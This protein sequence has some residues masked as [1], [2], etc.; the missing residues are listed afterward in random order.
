MAKRT[1]AKKQGQEF[2]EK[3]LR[4]DIM[5]EGRAIGLPSGTVKP[6]AATVAEKVAGWVAGRA[7]VTEDDLTRV[8]A[9]EL[10]K[11]NR[12]LAYVYKNRD[13]II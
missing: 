5:R 11:F 13:K 12:D 9:R 10:G 2:S 6:I 7:E 4:A 1:A 8:T 3:A